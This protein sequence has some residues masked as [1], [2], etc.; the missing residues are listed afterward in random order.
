MKWLVALALATAPQLAQAEQQSVAAYL[1][2]LEKSS[3]EACFGVESATPSICLSP[4]TEYTR[5][6]GGS[7]D[8]RAW[9]CEW[10]SRET[11]CWTE[12]GVSCS[13][14]STTVPYGSWE[15]VEL[16]TATPSQTFDNPTD[17]LLRIEIQ[18][19]IIDPCASELA[20][21]SSLTFDQIKLVARRSFEAVMREGLE[22][23]RGKSREERQEVYEASREICVLA[24][25]GQ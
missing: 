12:E 20:Q 16:A 23:V 22:R 13:C 11:W 19:E 18:K 5:R 21:G 8:S 4:W 24:I 2:P 9:V 7:L 25:G 6:N 14:S 1:L 3:G 15:R 10:K 17:F